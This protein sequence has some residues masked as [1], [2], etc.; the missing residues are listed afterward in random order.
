MCNLRT[1]E[2]INP[3]KNKQ[4][5]NEF[6]ALLWKALQENTNDNI[7]TTTYLVFIWSGNYRVYGAFMLHHSIYG[8]RLL[9]VV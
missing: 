1:Y 6:L 9:I 7:F 3:T 8:S 4:F 2:A 5:S